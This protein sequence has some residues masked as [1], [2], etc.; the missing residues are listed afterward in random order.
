MNV[1]RFWEENAYNSVSY[2]DDWILHVD[3]EDEDEDDEDEGCG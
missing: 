1:R 3:D 2:T